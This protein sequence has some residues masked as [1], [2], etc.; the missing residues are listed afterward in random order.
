MKII[1]IGPP[2]GGKGTQAKLLVKKFNIPQ[3]STGDMLREHVKNETDL[4]IA[5][6]GY[7]DSGQLVPDQL[8]LNMMETRFQKSDCENGYILDGFPRTI[9]QA[10]GLDKSLKKIGH[11]L[12]NIIVL[13]IKDD[14]IVDRMGGR[15]IHVSSG[16]IYHIKYN[17]PINHNKDDI[18]NEELS[19]RDDDKE[20]TV[21]DRLKVYHDLTSP[22]INYYNTKDIV[23]TIDGSLKIDEVNNKI[24]NILNNND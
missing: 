9:P 13:D 16:R 21:R 7:M 5:A 19:I 17:P 18:T 10:E 6:K 20:K 2:G 14:I 4:G 3:I 1:L 12:T 23:S 22:L 11:Q 8:I 24:I 15:R